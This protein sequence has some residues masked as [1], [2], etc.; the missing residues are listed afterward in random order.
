MI[1]FVLITF[2]VST[3]NAFVDVKVEETAN[4]TKKNSELKKQFHDL[5][6]RSQKIF[7]NFIERKKLKPLKIVGH[8]E[9]NVVNAYMKEYLQINLVEVSGALLRHHELTL[10][11]LALVICHEIGHA[12]GGKPERRAPLFKASVEGQSDY[13]GTKEC[14]PKILAELQPSTTL[15]QTSHLKEICKLHA[16]PSY[17]ERALTAGQSAANLLASLKDQAYPS[18]DTPDQSKVRRTLRG[19]PNSVQ[20][21]LDTFLAGVIGLVR[22]SCWYAGRG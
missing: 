7:N 2:H 1:F 8:W 5:I 4:P 13:Y 22:P 18:Y 19:F 10:D 6:S 12:Y 17:C 21:R 3:V 9:S 16:A 14:L 15:Q 20:C 11:G